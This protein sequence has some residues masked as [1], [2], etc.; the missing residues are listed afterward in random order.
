MPVVA[1]MRMTYNK[2]IQTKAPQD[3]PVIKTSKDPIWLTI[4]SVGPIRYKTIVSNEYCCILILLSGNFATLL[5]WKDIYSNRF[6][7]CNRSA[8]RLAIGVVA[9]PGV[10]PDQGT[11]VGSPNAIILT[12]TPYVMLSRYFGRAVL[13]MVTLLR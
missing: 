1:N 5:S 4:I 12:Q 13:I 11:K 2:R 7:D 9:L 6:L 8:E 10:Q 3:K